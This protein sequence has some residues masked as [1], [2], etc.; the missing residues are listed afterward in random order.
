MF[1]RRYT[2]WIPFANYSY[3]NACYII[4]VR[5][6]KKNGMMQFK[7]KSVHSWHKFK[8]RVLPNPLIDV[9]QSWDNIVNQ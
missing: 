3:A 7:T 1:K 5:K 6:N 8:A 2:N 9:K 4:F